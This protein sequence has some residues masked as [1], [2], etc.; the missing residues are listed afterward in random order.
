VAEALADLDVNDDGSVDFDEFV[1]IHADVEDDSGRVERSD[2][3]DHH[4]SIDGNDP[5]DHRKSLHESEQ[6]EE[7]NPEIAALK[8]QFS[9]DL[10]ANGDGDTL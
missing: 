4:P 5:F 3:F 8:R 7:I 1:A 2:S 6:E 9:G 10:D